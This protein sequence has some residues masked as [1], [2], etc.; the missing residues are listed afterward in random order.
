ME[1]N[2]FP[3]DKK[4]ITPERRQA[5]FH[6]A[7]DLFFMGRGYS[8]DPRCRVQLVNKWIFLIEDRHRQNIPAF[9]LAEDPPWCHHDLAQA[10]IYPH[11]RDYLN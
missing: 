3:T 5:R 1:N 8:W 7:E 9:R 10:P 4:E 11:Q 6:Q 2:N